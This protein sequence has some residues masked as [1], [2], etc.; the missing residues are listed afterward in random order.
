MSQ[1]RIANEITAG[2]PFAAIAEKLNVSLALVE[3]TWAEMNDPEEWY[4]VQI[5]EGMKL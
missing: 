1:I 5:T 3:T 2:L 4:F